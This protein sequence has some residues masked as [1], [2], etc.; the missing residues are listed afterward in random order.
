MA[1]RFLLNIGNTTPNVSPLNF[2]F[3]SS[4]ISSTVAKL[5]CALATIASVA[6][7]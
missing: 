4:A 1:K 6:A 5:P 2:V 7:I 3:M